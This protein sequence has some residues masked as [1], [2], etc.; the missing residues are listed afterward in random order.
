MSGH[1]TDTVI[2]KRSQNYEECPG[3]SDTFEISVAPITVADP[4]AVV[5]SIFSDDDTAA[6]KAAKTIC[7]ED[8]QM[9]WST[10]AADCV[11]KCD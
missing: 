5:E 11:V 1:C 4:T 10:T 7:E 2:V 9:Y 8:D 3:C 6:V